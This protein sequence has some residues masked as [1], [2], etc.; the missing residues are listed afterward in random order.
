M[1]MKNSSDTI[2]NRTRDLPA[3]SA[4]LQPTTCVFTCPN[5]IFHVSSFK[6]NTHKYIQLTKLPQYKMLALR[7]QF[8][9][10]YKLVPSSHPFK[11]RR[12]KLL[13]NFG[14][15][16]KTISLTDW[17]SEIDPHTCSIFDTVDNS[18]YAMWIEL[19]EPP[20]T[21]SCSIRL[22]LQVL[23]FHLCDCLSL[24]S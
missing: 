10:C 12:H 6:A 22:P 19:Q 4:V 21:S 2:G 13:L 3:C 17:M 16:T 7:K 1:S 24:L 15:G 9:Q 14:K 23:S 8:S 11:P 18:K 20:L 5:T